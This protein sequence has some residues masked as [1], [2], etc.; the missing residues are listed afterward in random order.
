[1]ARDIEPL[2]RYFRCCRDA[3]TFDDLRVA[4]TDYYG[5]TSVVMASYMHYP[6]VGA[7]DFDGQIRVGEFG[8]PEAWRETYLAEELHLC[9]PLARRAVNFTRPYFWSESPSLPNLT[10]DERDYLQRAAAQ[11]MGEG[12]GIP[13]FGPAGRNG[14][15]ALGFGR[16]ERPPAD[17]VLEL[18]AA[19][20]M[21]HLAYC[22]LLLRAL[23]NGTVLSAREREILRWVARGRTNSQIAEALQLSRNTVETYIRRSFEKL[24]VNDRVSAALRGIALGM[25]D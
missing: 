9:D 19:A 4:A 1:M 18:Q 12:I 16:P 7:H 10:P 2:R 13:L 17:E 20:Q 3:A 24:D 14:Y 23:P 8:Y 25:V 21:G 22:R 11:N 15:A 6:P 5:S